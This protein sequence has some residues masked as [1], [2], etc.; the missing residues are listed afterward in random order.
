[1]TS[2]PFFIYI[3]SYDYLSLK[4][5]NSLSILLHHCDHLNGR[6]NIAS[7]KDP[8][9]LYVLFL[10]CTFKKEEFIISAKGLS[11][12]LK[13]KFTAKFSEV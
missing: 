9:E 5:F 12:A 1:M 4:I 2:A 8:K 6:K 13:A 7:K 3:S 11:S 10:P